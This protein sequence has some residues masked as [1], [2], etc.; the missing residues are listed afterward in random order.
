MNVRPLLLVALLGLG[1]SIA[2]SVRSAQAAIRPFTSSGECQLRG[3]SVF[4]PPLSLKNQE[5]KV[6]FTGTLSACPKNSY[7]I[8]G[9]TIKTSGSGLATC[10]SDY[11]DTQTSTGAITWKGAKGTSTY[12]S[13]STAIGNSNPPTTWVTGTMTGGSPLPKGTSSEGETSF[14]ITKSMEKACKAGTLGQVSVSGTTAPALAACTLTGTTSFDPPLGL[15]NQE[16]TVTFDGAISA[17]AKNS[18]NITG[19]TVT[20]T[21]RGLDSCNPNVTDIV[22]SSGSIV[23]DGKVG[24]NTFKSTTTSL[25]NSDPTAVL[26]TGSITG[27]VPLP[28]GTPTGGVQSAPTSDK[29][30]T[31]CIEG[32]LRSITINVP[33]T[34]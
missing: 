27:G 17:C 15:T 8:T 25:V 4:R 13:R 23:W 14:K 20:A 26:V 12:T 30:A 33:T 18:D 34:S 10:S 7:G 6:T 32:A 2:H 1:L 16:T 11:S 5:T 21:G 24:T 9:G 28:I 22:K 31:E 3:M 19:G 29:L